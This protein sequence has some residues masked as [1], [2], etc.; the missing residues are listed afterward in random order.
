[1]TRRPNKNTKIA[2]KIMR[3]KC[4]SYHHGDGPFVLCWAIAWF[5]NLLAVWLNTPRRATSVPQCV[6]WQ[7]TD[8][9]LM[10]CTCCVV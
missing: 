7:S 3:L 1:V 8:K 4:F 9:A 10:G 6:D 2:V 5:D